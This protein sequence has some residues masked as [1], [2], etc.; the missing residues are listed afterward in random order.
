MKISSLKYPN[1]FQDL[2]I[3]L[4]LVMRTWI[5]HLRDGLVIALM[6][7]RCSSALRIRVYLLMQHQMFSL[8]LQDFAT[9][10]LE[11]DL[12]L[13]NSNILL[14]LVETSSL[15]AENHICSLLRSLLLSSTH[16]IS[17]NHAAFMEM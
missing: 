8:I 5:N 4:H 14:K 3:C 17:L 12:M 13:Y 11:V 7:L 16:L 6:M 15:K 10:L 9:K 2:Q 1:G